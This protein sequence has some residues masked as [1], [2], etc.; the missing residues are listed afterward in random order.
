MTITWNYRVFQEADGDYIIREVFY[1]EDG[2]ITACSAKAVEPSGRTFQ[3]LVEDIQS[4][5]EA[6]KL[7]ALTLKDIPDGKLKQKRKS[8]SSQN[9]S[10]QQ[11]MIELGLD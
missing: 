1:T 6:L 7:P 4:F 10:H 2:S 8:R 5:Q 11:L 3:E 9:I